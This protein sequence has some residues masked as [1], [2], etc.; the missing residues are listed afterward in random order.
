[1]KAKEETVEGEG[2]GPL[3]SFPEV[4]CP[5]ERGRCGEE[6][7]EKGD[8]AEDDGGTEANGEAES[9]SDQEFG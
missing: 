9:A 3:S 1:V 8:P 2:G 5:K 7:H 4:E 6:E